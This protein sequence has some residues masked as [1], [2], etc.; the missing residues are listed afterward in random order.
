MK[1]IP[2]RTS[3]LL[4]LL[5][6]FPVVGRAQAPV[7]LWVHGQYIEA[8]VPPMIHRD[9]TLVPLR[10]I[11]E[12]MDAQVA[13]SQWDRRVTITPQ[14]G[15]PILEFVV[16]QPTL[17][18]DGVAQALDTAPLIVRDRTMVPIRAIATAFGVPVDWDHQHRTAVVGW[19]YAPPQGGSP[20]DLLNHRPSPHGDHSPMGRIVIEGNAA[21]PE[22]SYTLTFNG[23]TIYHTMK[24]LRHGD[25]IYVPLFPILDEVH[26]VAQQ[27]GP[28][29]IAGL[30]RRDYDQYSWA[31]SLLDHGIHMGNRFAVGYI[32]AS[33]YASSEF[34]ID[35]DMAQ[36]PVYDDD[37]N[38][39]YETELLEGPPILID[40]MIFM[41]LQDI[42]SR[43]YLIP[44]YHNEGGCDLYFTTENVYR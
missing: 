14:S 9:R 35:Q 19:G 26:R 44:E 6:L 21:A 27:L 29:Y 28:Q 30:H 43:I 7:R 42:T 8:D 40:G 36:F 20:H 18:V 39:H 34:T 16:G 23:K 33:D 2:L 41:V 17:W 11:S 24:P 38:T 1:H 37:G 3:L 25:Y 12:A 32:E 10:V 15:S 4:L 22:Q 5:L 13:W 31:H